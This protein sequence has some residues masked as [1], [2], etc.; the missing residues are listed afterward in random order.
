MIRQIIIRLILFELITSR[1]E[2]ELKDEGLMF[3]VLIY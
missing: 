3:R 2:G 1:T